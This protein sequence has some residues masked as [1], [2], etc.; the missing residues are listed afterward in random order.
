MPSE[1]VLVDHITQCVPKL[2][3]DSF[4]LAIRLIPATSLLPI[5]SA[6]HGSLHPRQFGVSVGII[7]IVRN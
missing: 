2:G 1:H 3:P 7:P 5:L 4:L 6:I